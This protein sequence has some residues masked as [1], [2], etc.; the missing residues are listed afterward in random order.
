MSN[1]QAN[2]FS[3]LGIDVTPEVIDKHKWYAFWDAPLSIPGYYPGTARAAAGGGGGPRSAGA[4]GTDAWTGRHHPRAGRSPPVGIARQT[5][6]Q[7]ESPNP[8]GFTGGRGFGLPRTKEEIRR[9]VSAFSASSCE[10]KSD[11]AQ[12]RG[13]V[14]GDEARHL[15]RQPAVHRVSRDEPHSDGRHCAD[16]RAVGG[17]QVR[18]GAE[19]ILDGDDAQGRPGATP[20]G[21]RSSISSAGPR[22][23]AFRVF[24]R[25]TAC[26]WPK[27]RAAR[28][29]RSRRRTRSSSRAKWM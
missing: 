3:S 21:I 13:D 2:A 27:A 25:P 6:L 29:R 18:R 1:D 16:E 22:R 4:S 11:G 14:P 7:P 8:P 10:V 9:G 19:G 15:R 26:S 5:G 20:A 12:P 24:A 28:S 23:S 17:L